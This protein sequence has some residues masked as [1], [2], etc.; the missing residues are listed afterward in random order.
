MNDLLV[1]DGYRRAHAL[2]RT[3][4]KSFH[5]ASWALGGARRRGALAL[6]AFC[7]RLDDLVD[8]PSA[9]PAALVPRLEAARALVR[10]VCGPGAGAV[11]A[12]FDVAETAAL[13]DTIRRFAI[14]EAPLQDLIDGVAM[15]LTVH[16]YATAA[17]LDRY[18]YLVAG[19]VGLMMAPLLGY[20]DPAALAPA[21]A[22]GHAMQLTNILRDVGEDLA[23]DR[24]YLPQ[25]DLAAAGL[26]EA[27]LRAGRVDARFRACMQAQVARARALYAEARRGI[28]LLDGARSR[29]TVR[30]MAAVYGDIL[31]AIEAQ[32]YDVFRR[33]AVVSGGRKLVLAAAALGLREAPA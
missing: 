13:R 29:L 24:I 2:T 10:A 12:P 16:R 5:F 19:T 26:S 17:A 3:H 14:P 27:D 30:L 1:R 23:R 9:P 33:R 7:R 8:E 22:L 4:A 32:D 20:R 31:R 15:D 25:A 28:P 11:P 6:Y 21:A 18:C